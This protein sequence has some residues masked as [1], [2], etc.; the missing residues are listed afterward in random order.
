MDID[1][2]EHLCGGTV[3]CQ[4]LVYSLIN[5]LENILEIHIFSKKKHVLWATLPYRNDGWRYKLQIWHENYIGDVSG[6]Y[7]GNF[8]FISEPWAE[9]WLIFDLSTQTFRG[10]YLGLGVTNQKMPR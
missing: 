9:I 5:Y 3:D 6:G 8:L 2:G 1:G 10:P 4:K 7:R